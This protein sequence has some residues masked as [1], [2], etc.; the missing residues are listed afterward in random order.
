[1]SV[2]KR[3][4]QIAAFS[5][6]SQPPQDEA[7]LIEKCCGESPSLLPVIESEPHPEKE[8]IPNRISGEYN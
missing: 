2:L 1:M 6:G 4:F 5:T 7:E 8:S 3:F